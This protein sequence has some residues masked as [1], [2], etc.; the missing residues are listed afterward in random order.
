MRSPPPPSPFSRVETEQGQDLLN[1][2]P[3]PRIPGKS[4][5]SPSLLSP[6]PR[7]LFPANRGGSPSSSSP[8]LVVPPADA[9]FFMNVLF[10]SPW[11]R[12]YTL[13]FGAIARPRPPLHP[14]LCMLFFFVNF[15]P[16]CRCLTRI[17]HSAHFFPESFSAATRGPD[18]TCQISCWN[19]THPLG[20]CRFLFF[21]SLCSTRSD[22][23]PSAFPD[24]A[25]FVLFCQS[26]LL[27]PCP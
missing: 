13:F 5:F 11:H 7:T 14:P 9:P 12:I 23:P 3:I 15:P 6:C 10:R 16:E 18:G 4:I 20:H 2:F 22:F 27:S 1:A 24:N 17:W 19:H 25:F 26:A 8:P 21:P